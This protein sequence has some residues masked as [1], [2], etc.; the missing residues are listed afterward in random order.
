[1]YSNVRKASIALAK[2]LKKEGKSKMTKKKP[3]A[4]ERAADEKKPV[5]DREYTAD[6]LAIWAHKYTD[7][8]KGQAKFGGFDRIGI[9]AM[10]TWKKHFEENYATRRAQ[11]LVHEEFLLS[12]LKAK[13]GITG[14]NAVE[15]AKN[16]KKRKSGDLEPTP[17]AQEP[18]PN[19]Y[20]FSD[21]EDGISA[22]RTSV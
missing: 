11:I 2:Y 16:Q 15:N 1:M 14:D 20:N 4:A 6:Y 10:L 3:T 19:L 7:N 21:D 13:H 18:V 5:K 22:T 12:K 9:V 8:E 17:T